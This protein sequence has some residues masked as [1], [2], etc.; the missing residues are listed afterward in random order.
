MKKKNIADIRISFIIPVYNR[1]KEVKELLESM[2]QQTEHEF[3]VIIVADK[4]YKFG[5]VK[6]IKEN[7]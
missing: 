5:K 2:V 1:P 4:M 6:D 3:E 7:D